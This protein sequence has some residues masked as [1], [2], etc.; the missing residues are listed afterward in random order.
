M[1]RSTQIM[2]KISL[3][4][5]EMKN[6]M[7]AGK[8]DEAH[9]KVGEIA[10]L[11]KELDVQ[12]KLEADEDNDTQSVETLNANE[13]EA[14]NDAAYKAAFFKA[15]KRKPLDTAELAILTV[16]GAL[17]SST[18]ED[19]GYLLPKDQQTA[20]KEL[21]RS[22]PAFEKYVNVE[23]VT[24]LSGSR[25]IEKNALYTPFTLFAEGEDVPA[26]GTP[27]FVNVPY[28]IKDRGGILPVPNNLMNDTDVAIEK[29]LNKWL[30]KKSVAT[31]NSIILTLLNTLTKKAV[32]DLDDIKEIINLNLDPAIEAGAK[33]FTNQS[34]FNWLDT[35]KDLDD[36]YLVQPN[37]LN[38][39]QKMLFGKYEIVVFSD[40]ALPNR[41]DGTNLQAPMIIGDLMEA[42]TLFDR[43]QMSLL[44]TNVGGDAFKKNR[45]DI[46]AIER[47]DAKL[48]D[49][50]AVVFGEINV[51]AAE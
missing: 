8:I 2:Q 34:G 27:Q 37:P 28:E 16:Q 4:K 40:K 30:A 21:K 50:E 15:F 42:V 23:P 26:S 41:D 11:E 12:L 13:P 45:T 25:N 51:G 24:N 18:G 38:P 20:I 22:L 36:R 29:Y 1:K 35:L 49:S 44:A 17:S 39:T 31:R 32:T 5:N 3:A 43:E 9:A 19:G 47:E 6:L 14:V 10:N 46:R 33:V 48:V 7:E